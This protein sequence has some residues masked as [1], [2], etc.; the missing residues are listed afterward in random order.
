MKENTN[1]RRI[2]KGSIIGWDF[3]YVIVSTHIK[4][5]KL[6]FYCICDNANN[7]YSFTLD[8]ILNTKDPHKWLILSP[9]MAMKIH[10]FGNQYYL[11]EEDQELYEK[12][13]RPIPAEVIAEVLCGQEDNRFNHWYG[14][15]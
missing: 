4:D 3:Y 5:N 12:I 7:I 14:N 8:E 15:E 13:N 6:Y 10:S 11:N 2:E 9:K 1:Y